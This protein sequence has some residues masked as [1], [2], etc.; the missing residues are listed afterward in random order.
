[1]ERDAA[2]DV[3]PR[4]I[5]F[6][7][8]LLDRAGLHGERYRA[9]PLA[10]RYPSVLRHLRASTVDEAEARL[11]HDPAMLHRIV[12]LLLLGVTEFFRDPPL[13]DHVREIVLP[14]MLSRAA[15][16][17]IW[18][19]GCSD[20][21]ELTSVAILLQEAGGLE[22]AELLGTDCRP[23]AIRR[24]ARGWYS[25]E[26]LRRVPQAVRER[27]FLERRGGYELR[28]RLRARLA[29]RL[30]DALDRTEAGPWD[31]ILCRNVAMYLDPATAAA[32]WNSLIASLRPGGW[33]ITGHAERRDD[34]RVAAI[35]PSIHRRT[36]PDG[37]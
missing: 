35:R 3:D 24:A 22:R 1:V 4:G 12:E 19:V 8:G 15:S 34:R 5:G 6:L 26:A 23:E 9:G 25:R 28:D 33:L 29:W 31:L 37:A 13:F 36:E 7:R 14:S 10:R 17:R 30:A 32:L 27:S 11:A 21:S 16:P 18:S 20:G 2:P